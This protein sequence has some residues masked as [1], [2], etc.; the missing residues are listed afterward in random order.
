VNRKHKRR[1]MNRDT[2]SYILL[3]TYDKLLLLDAARFH[4]ND[5]SLSEESKHL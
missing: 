5:T 2:G 3:S 4:Q 1:A